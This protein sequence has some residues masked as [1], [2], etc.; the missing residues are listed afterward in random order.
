MLTKWA[1][2]P[3]FAVSETITVVAFLTFAIFL[4]SD[5]SAR[6]AIHS[7]WR[8][9]SLALLIL[10]AF[11]I[12]LHGTFFH[13]MEYEDSYVYSVSSRSLPPLS[14]T[15]GSPYLIGTCVGGSFASC[16]LWQTYSGHYIGYAAILR[17]ATL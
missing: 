8:L 13:G 11:R 17:L 5:R 16:A 4:V 2:L 9:V 7:E 14:N 6:T 10:V 15:V 3:P 12:P 1:V